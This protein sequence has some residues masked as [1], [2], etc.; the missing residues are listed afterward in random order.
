MTDLSTISIAA[1]ALTAQTTSVQVIANN[2]ANAQTPGYTAQQA[3][4]VPMNPG[5]SVG[6]VVDTGHDVDLTSET[7]N[8]LNAK[9]AY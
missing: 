7:L 5:V 6:A 9:A 8:L 4:F 1:S 3:Q 2:V